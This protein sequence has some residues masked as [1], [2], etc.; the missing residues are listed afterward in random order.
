M[1]GA[2]GQPLDSASATVPLP[3]LIAV[4]ATAR[5]PDCRVALRTAGRAAKASDRAPVGRVAASRAANGMTATR[6]VWR[7]NS[8]CCRQGE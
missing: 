4:P 6:G 3:T 5:T 8:I 7:I 2:P 1:S